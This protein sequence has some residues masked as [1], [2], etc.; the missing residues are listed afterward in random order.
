[1]DHELYWIS[2]SP[3]SWRVQLALEYKQVPYISRRL[4]T[5]KKENRSPEF[6]ALNPR[7]KVPVLTTGGTAICDPSPL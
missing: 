7:G 2:G 3:Y 4:D 5:G 1:M 6:L